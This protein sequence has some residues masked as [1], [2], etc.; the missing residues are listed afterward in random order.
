MEP[1]PDGHTDSVVKYVP[2]FQSVLRAPAL[3]DKP[4]GAWCGPAREAD[5]PGSPTS[6]CCV[7]GRRMVMAR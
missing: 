3:T 1:S 2:V 7:G 5:G 6:A 4:L